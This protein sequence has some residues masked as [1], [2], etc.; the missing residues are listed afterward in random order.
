MRTLTVVPALFLTAMPWVASA[1]IPGIMPQIK[2]NRLAP[3]V[4]SPQNV[5]EE[6]LRAAKVKVGDTVYDLGSG[7]GR[8][9]ITAAQKFG[10]KA[11]GIEISAKEAKLSREKIAHAKLEDRVKIIEADALTADLS[12]ADVVTLY[13]LTSSNDLLRPHLE[14]M[15]KPGARVVSHDYPIRGWKETRVEQV[16]AFKRIHHLYIYEIPAK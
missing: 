7:D 15:L 2:P 13:F 9:V 5:V 11:V 8:V 10:A 6:M 16:E 4:P 1:Q 14:K 3:Y 12:G